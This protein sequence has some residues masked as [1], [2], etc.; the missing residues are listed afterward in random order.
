MLN[1]TYAVE[2]GLTEDDYIAF[3]D[4]ELCYEGAPTTRTE[5]VQEETFQEM[6]VESVVI[7]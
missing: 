4:L 5:P 6:G 7:G 1:D 3:P 2:F